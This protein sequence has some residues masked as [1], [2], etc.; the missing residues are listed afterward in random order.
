[1]KYTVVDFSQEMLIKYNSSH[2]DATLD[3]LDLHIFQW[4]TDFAA[5]KA[6]QG[7]KAMWRKVIDGEIYC[8]V[9]YGAIIDEF[10]FLGIQSERSVLR[11]FDK[12]VLGGLMKKKVIGTANGGRKVFFA[13]TEEF[14]ALRYSRPNNFEQ[15][16]AENHETTNLSFRENDISNDAEKSRNDETDRSAVREVTKSSFHKADFSARSDSPVISCGDKMTNLSFSLKNPPTKINSTTTSSPP[17]KTDEATFGQKNSQKTQKAERKEAEEEF[18]KT[19]FKNALEKAFGFDPHFSRDLLPE[20][21]KSF[22]EVKLEPSLLDEYVIWARERL[23]KSCRDEQKFLGY[24]YRAMSKP[25]LVAVFKG[26]KLKENA[27]RT[28]F[29][30]N[31]VVCPACSEKFLKRDAYCP[32]CSLNISDFGDK[33]KVEKARKYASLAETERGNYDKELFSFKSEMPIP[34]RLL[35]FN[36]I[37]GQKEKEIF[38]RKLDEKYGI[39]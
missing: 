29:E 35:F 39:A 32:N 13:L 37:E 26:E 1:M 2:P 31:S 9:R 33:A 3:F 16:T 24:F 28:E 14:T 21:K 4:F 11:R 19:K 30:S 5:V 34:Q 22:A 17:N 7:H 15:T 27:K 8:N 23:S 12:Y 6:R 10:P 25:H 20:L 18:S 38:M 36:T